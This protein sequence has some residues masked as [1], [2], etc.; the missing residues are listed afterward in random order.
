MKQRR[1]LDAMRH[2]GGRQDT[3]CWSGVGHQPV[4]LHLSH[5]NPGVSYIWQAVG[6]VTHPAH[7]QDWR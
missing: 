5:L 2:S 1:E 6:A 3:M 4:A 7:A